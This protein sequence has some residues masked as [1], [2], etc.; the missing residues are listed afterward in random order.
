MVR[1][2]LRCAEGAVRTHFRIGILDG[3]EAIRGELLVKQIVAGE[4]AFVT[5]ELQENVALGALIEIVKQEGDP[6]TLILQ[7]NKMTGS[8]MAADGAAA[9][10]S[11][12]EYVEAAGA[13]EPRGEVEV[14]FRSSQT[15][16]GLEAASPGRPESADKDG[17]TYFP[18]PPKLN[19]YSLSLRADR[20]KEKIA[21]L[22]ALKLQI[23]HAEMLHAAGEGSVSEEQCA[24]MCQATEEE[25]LVKLRSFHAESFEPWHDVQTKEEQRSAFDL[26]NLQ[27]TRQEHRESIDLVSTRLRELEFQR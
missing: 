9:E 26:A 18:V 3:D 20:L 25:L 2:R 7:L 5:E 8:P 4:P 10:Q 24:A 12:I 14:E 19:E 21:E 27:K 1:F 6:E 16:L 17:V 11:C 22:K 13:E 15:H 23:A